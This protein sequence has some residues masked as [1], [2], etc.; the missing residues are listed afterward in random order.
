MTLRPIEVGSLG[1]IEGRVVGRQLRSHGR[2]RNHGRMHFFLSNPSDGCRDHVQKH[3]LPSDRRARHRLPRR[4]VRLWGGLSPRRTATPP[5]FVDKILKGEKPGNIPIEQAAKFK[6]VINLRTAK[7]LGVEI[8]PVAACE[9]ERGDRIGFR[10]RSSLVFGPRMT[11]SA[12]QKRS[13]QPTTGVQRPA[14]H[15]P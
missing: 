10:W 9:R 4:P 8:P 5:V 2:S 13:W 15:D 11:V 3:G 1:E 14:G 7:A 12:H 6:M